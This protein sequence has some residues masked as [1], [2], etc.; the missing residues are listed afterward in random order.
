MIVLIVLMLM[1]ILRCSALYKDK[2]ILEIFELREVVGG[3]P[4]N[5]ISLD[6]RGNETPKNPNFHLTH[7]IN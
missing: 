5:Q 4:Q 3:Y 2:Y 6:V 1:I 7:R